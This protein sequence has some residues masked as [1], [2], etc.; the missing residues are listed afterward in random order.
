MVRG[1]VAARCTRQRLIRAVPLVPKGDALRRAVAWLAE[2][3][4]W[5]PEL[6]DE[7]SQRFDLSPLDEQFLL[8]ECT[9]M[10]AHDGPPASN[11]S[12]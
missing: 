2:Q 8:Q 10:R 5:T 4:P 6:V 1:S 7:A 11:P 12:H 9:R 3:G